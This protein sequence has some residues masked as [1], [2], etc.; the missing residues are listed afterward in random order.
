[1]EHAPEQRTCQN[2]KNEFVI[3][4]EDFYFYKKIDVPPS[5]YC[6]TCKLQRRMMFRNERTLYRRPNNAPGQEGE[7]II[8]IHRSNISRTVYDDRTWWSDAWD[9]VDYGREY[10]FS[11]S[12]F[13]QYGELYKRIPLINLS[14]TNMSNCSYCNVSEGDKGSYMISASEQN[15]DCIYSNRVARNKQ[16]GDIYI[17]TKNEL[18]Y[19]LVN[20]TSNFKVRFA[21]HAYECA[22]SWFLYNCKSCTNCIGCVN[23][24]NKSYCIFNEQLDRENYIKRAGQLALDTRSGVESVRKRFEE[25]KKKN[26]RRYANMIRTVQSTGDNLEGA[27][28]AKNCY[29]IFDAEHIKNVVW[30]GYGLS[31]SRDVGPGAGVETNLIYDALDTGLGSSLL[32]W[33]SVVYHSMDVR[34]SINCHSSSHIFGCYGLRKKEYCILNKQYTKEEYE[35]LLPKIKRHMQEMPYVDRKGRKFEYGDFFPYDLTPFAYNETIAQEYFPLTEEEANK[36]GLSWYAREE[37]NYSI[38]VKNDAIPDSIG[39]VDDSILRETFACKNEGNQLSQCTGAFRIVPQELSLYRQ[40]GVPLPQY[41]YNCRH[42]NRLQQR[43]PMK[44]WKRK[45]MCGST[46]S[47]QATKYQNTVKHSHGD[48]PCPNEFETSYAPEREEIVYCE[49]C[50]QSEVV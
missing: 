13:E 39:E 27:N 3:E 19:E 33:T 17:G 31:D 46:S 35:T 10:D 22:D 41:C 43:N 8:S 47:P 25:L 6:T 11:R 29:D 9:P 7:Q 36:K 12:F 26:I 20:A 18:C 2:C 37:R 5:N 50:Y 1:M 15:E 45:C 44:L 21:E 14:V 40:L 4:S 30:G 48:K 42:Y 38:T 32:F 16:S 34:Y 23:L 28:D 49:Q 24:R